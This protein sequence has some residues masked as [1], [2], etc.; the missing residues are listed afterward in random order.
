MIR[1]LFLPLLA[2][3]L[4]LAAQQDSGPPAQSVADAARAARERQK[5][6]NSRRVLTDDDMAS[7]RKSSDSGASPT[8][9]AQTRAQLE[10]TYPSIPTVEEMRNQIDAIAGYSKDPA[11]DLIVKFKQ[12]AIYGYETVDFPG[13]QEW[14]DQL[15]SATTHFSEE[16]VNAT[17]RLQAL[18]EQ[19]R[20]ALSRQGPEVGQKVRAQWIEFLVPYTSWQIRTQ[21]LIVEGQ[22]RAKAYLAD[23]AKALRDYRSNRAAQAE[24]TVGW[25]LISLREEEEE[26][27]KNHGR[28]TCELSD[29]SFNIANPSKPQNSKIGWDSKMDSL[30]NLG[31]SIQMQ[32]CDADHFAALAAPPAVDGTQGRAFCSTEAGIRVATDGSTENCLSTGR[33]WH[34]Q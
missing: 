23:S 24:S 16:A 33:D 8:T 18:V 4:A 14:E 1:S 22:S 34:G 21:Q 11:A 13:R 25:A 12:A 6:S 28:Y 3:L 26:F 29:F 20:D 32:G 31:Y 27:H 5:S 7:A 2:A 15:E 19:N 17:Q 10:K 30:R 9:E